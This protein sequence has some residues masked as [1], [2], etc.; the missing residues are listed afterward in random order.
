MAKVVNFSAGKDLFGRDFKVIDTLNN[1]KLVNNQMRD[2]FNDI[3][4]Y[5][6][7]QAEAKKPVTVMDYQD[8]I[9]KH[10][11]AGSAELLGLS[12]ADGKKLE[13][14]SYSDVFDFYA[15][16]ADKFLSMQVPDPTDIKNSIQSMNDAAEQDPKSNA[17][18]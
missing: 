6:N 11:I 10:V 5:E 17:D 7:K 9:S 16:A 1:I 18:N 2:M 14:I 15:D 13:T 3:E 4:K 8:I 12:K